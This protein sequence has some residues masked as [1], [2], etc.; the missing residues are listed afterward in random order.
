MPSICRRRS[1]IYAPPPPQDFGGWYLRGD[2]GMTNQSMTISLHTTIGPTQG[3]PHA[4]AWAS[5]LRTSTTSASAIS[6]TTGSAPMSPAS[7]VACPTFTASMF[8]TGPA[9]RRLLGDN[10]HGGQVRTGSAMVNGYVD[11][12]TWWC[13]TPF[14][15]AGVGSRAITITASAMTAFNTGAGQPHV[16]DLRRRRL[17]RNFAWALHAGRR[18]QGHANFTVELAY[19]YHDLG[20]A[21]PV[22]RTPSTA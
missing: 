6:S 1:R 17:K 16:L 18:L 11:L 2:I 13:M 8:P 14:V 10:Y 7:I 9:R 12:G 4:D 5:T 19:R 20:M 15:G 21:S 3:R 22:R